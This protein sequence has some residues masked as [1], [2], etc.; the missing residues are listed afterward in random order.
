MKT[1]Y[2]KLALQYYGGVGAF[3]SMAETYG[4]RLE[5]R[6]RS[7]WP[8]IQALVLMWR[9]A[10]PAICKFWEASDLRQLP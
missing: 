3:C 1:R 5:D 4:L 6:A 10:H 2:G 8:V 7:A 9:A